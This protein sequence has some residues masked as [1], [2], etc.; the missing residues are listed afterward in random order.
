MLFLA[1][2]LVL[3]LAAL[4]L[5]VNRSL[6]STLEGESAEIAREFLEGHAIVVNHLNG[7]EDLDKPALYYWIIAL[8]SKLVHKWELAARLPSI[9][10][11]FMLALAIYLIGSP[12]D[13][14]LLFPLT[15]FVMVTSPK[16]LLMSQTAR[17]D[18]LF[19]AACFG[20]VVAFYL[21]WKG[22]EEEG[23]GSGFPV[24]FFVLAACA[25]LLKG[26]VGAILTFCPVAIFICMERRWHMLRSVFL[27]RGMILFL[28][29]TVPWFVAATVETN[30][31]FFH[32]FVLEE[33]LSRFTS[34]IPGGTFKNFSHH[35]MNR[36]FLYFLAGFF[37]WSI[38]WPFWVYEVVRNWNEKDSKAK[39]FFI[40]FSFIF[41]FFTMAIS[42]RSDYILPLY[43]AGAFLTAQFILKGQKRWRVEAP[44]VAFFAI[45]F[46]AA[47]LLSALSFALIFHGPEGLPH[48]LS[49]LKKLELY[50][51]LLLKYP[52][53][54]ATLVLLA[55]VNFVGLISL[56]VGRKKRHQG[57]AF[58]SLSP[59]VLMTISLVLF[60]T[61]VL[62]SI[63]KEKDTRGFCKEV[64]CLV[65]NCPLY[66]YDFWD[67]ECTFYLH[68]EINA[69]YGVERLRSEI[70]KGEKIFLILRDSQL[71]T[72]QQKGIY[73]PFVCR[74]N[75]PPLRPLVLVC[76]KPMEK[77]CDSDSLAQ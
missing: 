72:L 57:K 33:N 51:F 47:T 7:Q 37:P 41:I 13:S 36:Y 32:R 28:V 11:V 4:Y 18:M 6:S 31:R 44:Y 62:S 10:S 76:N 58:I 14:R 42:K 50:S 29:L 17:M 64:A 12:S 48:F 9:A 24:G 15:C 68:R 38:I 21:F 55:T 46:M 73:F 54:V 71:R 23:A 52:Y 25:V 1:C 22:M 35:P 66:Y 53:L 63:Y 59:P 40:Y 45:M 67:E 75:S 69:I 60:V 26:P 5:A 16:V 77:Y 27:G 20:S 19:T 70:N 34:M 74:K 3:I 39:L 56:C 8:V 65:K 43:P 2:S 49:R 61:V 30:F